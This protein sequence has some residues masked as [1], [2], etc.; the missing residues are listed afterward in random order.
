MKMSFVAPS[1][2]AESWFKVSAPNWPTN[3]SPQMLR[4]QYLAQMDFH[5]PE[6]CLFLRGCR[7]SY[8]TRGSHQEVVFY[9]D[10]YKWHRKDIHAFPGKVLTLNGNQLEISLGG[11]RAD[12][13]TQKE[14][15][16][17][18]MARGKRATQA[19]QAAATQAAAA[20]P[21]TAAGA[22]NPFAAPPAAPAPAANP[23]AGTPPAAPPVTRR[24]A[25]PPAA[26][27]APA[28]PFANAGGP[29]VPPPPVG[30]T[31]PNP[32]EGAIAA[33]HHVPGAGS[34]GVAAPVAQ[35]ITT[36]MGDVQKALSEIGGLDKELKSLK[37]GLK[38]L[39]DTVS[40]GIVE[41][42]A[43]I[44]RISNPPAAPPAVGQATQVTPPPAPGAAA[45]PPVNQYNPA[46][47]PAGL[48]ETQQ[49]MWDTINPNLAGFYRDNPGTTKQFKPGENDADFATVA[50]ML[51][52]VMGVDVATMAQPQYKGYI[53]QTLTQMG[54]LRPEGYL[55]PVLQG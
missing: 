28:N 51:S 2:P 9:F 3:W 37:K 54:L 15:T 12:K 20:S 52:P 14:G 36:V 26:P 13:T 30:V 6:F 35:A 19:N 38:S 7:C 18:I 11:S 49:K 44:S 50:G 31:T 25:V 29:P 42:Q 24:S 4:D 41:L 21:A 43:A 22:P 32:I 53:L 47:A 55:Y 33:Q 16:D 34:D 17:S 10:D 46:P 1:L 27:P 23:F 5:A 40:K 45:A 48:D 8:H 39:E